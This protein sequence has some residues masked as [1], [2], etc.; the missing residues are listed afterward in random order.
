MRHRTATTTAMFSDKSKCVDTVT[1]LPS[2][3]RAPAVG[4]G[5]RP[6]SAASYPGRSSAM[7]AAPAYV[8]G[9]SGASSNRGPVGGVS[10]QHGWPRR[11]RISSRNS[12]GS[13][14]TIP[15]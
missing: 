7:E 5:I 2:Q 3:T 10:S 1:E 15:A 4:A 11:G 14:S 6:G 13:T 12:S 9:G 8:E